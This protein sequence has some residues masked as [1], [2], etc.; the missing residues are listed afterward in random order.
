M[1]VENYKIEGVKCWTDL[2]YFLSVWNAPDLLQTTMA[3]RTG[4][5]RRHQAS[6]ILHARVQFCV[7]QRPHL[8]AHCY[9]DFNKIMAP[10]N[11]HSLMLP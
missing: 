6:T 3:R 8:Q 2:T 4:Y 11:E 5:L 7:A 9:P 1:I 10:E